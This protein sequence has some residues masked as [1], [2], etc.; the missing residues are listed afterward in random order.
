MVL[1]NSHPPRRMKNHEQVQVPMNWKSKEWTQRFRAHYR[2][3]IGQPLAA[4]YIVGAPWVGGAVL[5]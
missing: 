5:W 3:S 2:L 4:K 1:T